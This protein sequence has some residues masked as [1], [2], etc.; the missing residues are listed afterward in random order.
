M[1]TKPYEIKAP[2]TI[3]ENH[4][5]GKVEFFLY[6]DNDLLSTF[7]SYDDACDYVA[8]NSFLRHWNAYQVIVAII[9]CVFL[10]NILN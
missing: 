7:S 9:V 2:F 5:N 3:R 4:V 6:R 1:N 8:S 10:Y